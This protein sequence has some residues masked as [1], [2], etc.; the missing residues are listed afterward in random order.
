[1]KTH[2]HTVGKAAGGKVSRTWQVW[3][4]MRKRC[5]NENCSS[6][7][8]YGGRGIRVHKRWEKF[9]NFLAD[10]GE[11]PDGRTLD[12][13][14]VNGNYTP[15]NCRW[16]TWEEQWAN[17]RQNRKLTFRGRTQHLSAWAREFGMSQSKLSARLNKFGW[18]LEEA[19]T[20]PNHSRHPATHCGRGHPLTP[21][22]TYY[23]KKQEGKMRRQCRKCTLTRNRA[24]RMVNGGKP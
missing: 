12:R 7:P 23:T 6:Y 22:N 19:L 4:A 15:H 21:A 1:M 13:I 24:W 9:E 3:S 2:G 14:N 5:H 10:M 17:T 16:A 18:S 11:C 8:Y 20:W